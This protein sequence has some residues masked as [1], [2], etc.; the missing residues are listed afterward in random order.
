MATCEK[1]GRALDDEYA[2]EWHWCTECRAKA[3]SAPFGN[4]EICGKALYENEKGGICSTC[5]QNAEELYESE[6]AAFLPEE[7]HRTNSGK[8]CAVILAVGLLAIIIFACLSAALPRGAHENSTTSTPAS[9]AASNAAPSKSVYEIERDA[10]FDDARSYTMDAIRA[11]A[12][13]PESVNISDHNKNKFRGGG[14]FFHDYGQVTF[15]D[16]AGSE[17][18]EPYEHTYVTNG[19]DYVSCYLKIGD[20]V[21]YDYTNFID[22]DTGIIISASYSIDGRSFG[23]PII[24]GKIS[25]SKDWSPISPKNDGKI[26]EEKYSKI[27][28]DV[29]I[30]FIQDVQELVPTITGKMK[31]DYQSYKFLDMGD[32]V[33][34]VS[35]DF[36]SENAFGVELKYTATAAYDY[37]DENYT[38]TLMTLG[39]DD[40]V[41]YPAS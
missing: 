9:S 22:P 26:P 39:V 11:V 38:I 2:K 29:E 36:T 13:R 19:N 8:G 7:K 12:S 16:S 28:Y 18:D 10:D 21:M 4:C 5:L 1:C 34:A 32:N 14:V 6:R 23:E 3:G 33:L 40:Q 31:F 20:T 17:R 30:A 27:K 24:E 25:S 41:Y 35:I 15:T 37:D